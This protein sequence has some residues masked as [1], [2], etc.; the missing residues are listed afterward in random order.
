[1]SLSSCMELLRHPDQP[2]YLGA[3]PMS[4][5]TIVNGFPAFLV[6]RWGHGATTAA[7]ALWG[8]DAALAGVCVLLLPL[9]LFVHHQHRCAA[10][11]C[12]GGA[13]GQSVAGCI[14][15]VLPPP[16]TAG[17]ASCCVFYCKRD[18]PECLGMHM[19]IITTPL[20]CRTQISKGQDAATR[21][22]PLTTWPALRS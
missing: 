5:A 16:G 19:P 8:V 18:K 14:A 7:V 15:V 11:S 2:L 3:L 22:V 12:W 9:H 1:M 21:P 17:S 13:S 4:L 20:R 10:F 6:P